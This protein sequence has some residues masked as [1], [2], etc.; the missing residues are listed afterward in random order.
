MGKLIYLTVTRPDI[1][2]SVYILTQFMQAPTTEHL[3]TAKKLLRFLTGNSG[4]G[5]L[6]A[7]TSAGQLTAFSNSDWTGC[8]FSRRSTSGYY[9]MLADSPM[10]WKTKKQN[11][12]SRSS[13][14]V[15]M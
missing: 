3:L 5:I 11:V 14:K 1:V 4:Q 7:T 12:V 8:E 13:A 10:S 6:L 15:E 2:Y 9:I